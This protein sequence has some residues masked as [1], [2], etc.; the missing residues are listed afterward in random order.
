VFEDALIE[1]G[2]LIVV[3][4][5]AADGKSKATINGVSA[6]ACLPWLHLG[7]NFVREKS[8]WTGSKPHHSEIF[9]AERVG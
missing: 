5:V 1:D 3:R 7:E 6:T 9:A 2:E 8:A 4:T